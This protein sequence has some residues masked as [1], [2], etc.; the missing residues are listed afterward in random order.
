MPGSVVKARSVGYST[1]SPTDQHKEACS[2]RDELTSSHILDVSMRSTFGYAVRRIARY[3]QPR[4]TGTD[5]YNCPFWNLG[6]RLAFD[7]GNSGVVKAL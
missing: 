6:I 5:V 3:C 1:N 2:G 7:K 4:Q